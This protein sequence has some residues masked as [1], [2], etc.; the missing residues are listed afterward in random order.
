VSLARDRRVMQQVS[1]TAST[2][3]WGLGNKHTVIRTTEIRVSVQK[4]LRSGDGLSRMYDVP[5]RAIEIY[6]ERKRNHCRYCQQ[7]HEVKSCG[8][9]NSLWQLCKEALICDSVAIGVWSEHQG[10]MGPLSH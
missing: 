6:P 8:L 7:S 3:F 10:P 1:E 5:C 2:K 9:E 4:G